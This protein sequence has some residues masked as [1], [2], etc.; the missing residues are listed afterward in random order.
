MPVEELKELEVELKD[1]KKSEGPPVGSERWNEIYWKA[2]EGERAIEE[3]KSLKSESAAT[4]ELIEAM[5]AHNAELVATL[6]G[7]VEADQ[8]K[9]EI[10]KVEKE[11]SDLRGLKR[12]AVEKADFARVEEIDDSL[13]DLKLKIRDLKAAKTPKDGKRPTDGQP[14]DMIEKEDPE[15][16]E[17]DKQ[18]YSKW[19]DEN[20]WFTTNPRMR[21]S[22]IAF[23]KEIWKDPDFS[24]ATV[25]EVLIEVGNRVKEKFKGIDTGGIDLVEGSKRS[26]L[27]SGGTVKF[28]PVELEIAKGFGLPPEEIAKQKQIVATM[29]AQGRIR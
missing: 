20:K 17:D 3:L 18:I 8:Q 7:D 4:K 22:A 28:S 26:S 13:F 12:Q 23:E 9:S 11:I 27:P 6:R 19:I 16:S 25:E 15:L 14:V 10:E 5:K 29:K 21:S 2:K 24:A 1:E